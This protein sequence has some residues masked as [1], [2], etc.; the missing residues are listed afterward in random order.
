MAATGRW[1]LTVR[2]T[3]VWPIR[4][5]VPSVPWENLNPRTGLYRV[6]LAVPGAMHQLQACQFVR[7][8]QLG[9][10]LGSEVVRLETVNAI[11][12]TQVRPDK[13]VAL[14][15][16]VNTRT[17]MAQRHVKSAL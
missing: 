13:L 15:L 14:V 17:S 1:E 2:D 9:A 4:G 7:N 11:S 3:R 16:L 8:A 10:P 5:R 12:V 6:H